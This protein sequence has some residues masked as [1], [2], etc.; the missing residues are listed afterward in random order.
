MGEYELPVPPSRTKPYARAYRR[1]FYATIA[2]NVSREI[3]EAF[4]S[5]CHLNGVSMHAAIKA[6]AEEY[7]ARGGTAPAHRPRCG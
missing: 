4:R 1:E 5:A 3:Y 6:F 2:A 7:I